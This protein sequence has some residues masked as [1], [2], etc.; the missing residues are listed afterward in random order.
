MKLNHCSYI[1]L[2]KVKHILKSARKYMMSV[3]SII[4]SLDGLTFRNQLMSI[5]LVMPT[6]QYLHAIFSLGGGAMR[7][8][9]IL[10]RNLRPNYGT[11][12]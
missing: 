12:V 4:E 7:Q 2:L 6:G 5:M 11:C 3:L 10:D 1:A 8:P 9:V